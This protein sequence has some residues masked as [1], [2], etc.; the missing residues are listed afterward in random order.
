MSYQFFKLYMNI[1]YM[2]NWRFWKKSKSETSSLNTPLLEAKQEAERRIVEQEAEQ[3]AERRKVE[4]EAQQEAEREEAERREAEMTEAKRLKEEEKDFFSVKVDY[5]NNID[6]NDYKKTISEYEAIFDH[7]NNLKD[8]FKECECEKL[9]RELIEG[10]KY[11]SDNKN[12]IKALQQ[13]KLKEY[14]PSNKKL[15]KNKPVPMD[16][17]LFNGY[18]KGGTRKG[19][20]TTKRVKTIKKRKWSNK[21]KKSINCKKPKGFSQK[22]YCKS[23]KRR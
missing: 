18:K 3:E 10:S 2:V 20:K 4:Q 7:V 9:D 17:N 19:S 16:N 11:L 22:Q 8:K 5:N 1:Y 12:Y 23:K 21:Y 6:G 13:K 14:N 15:K